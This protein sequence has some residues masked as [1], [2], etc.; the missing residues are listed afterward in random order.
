MPPKQSKAPMGKP[1]NI[2]QTIARIFSYM[3]S[4][5]LHLALAVLCVM[6]SAAASHCRH[7]F[8]QAAD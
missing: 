5:R 3:K 2:K 6:V 7:L 1:Q 8:S 4:F